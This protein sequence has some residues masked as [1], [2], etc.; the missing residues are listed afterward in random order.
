MEDHLPVPP[1][2]RA[3]SPQP[4]TGEEEREI[5]MPQP[6]PIAQEHMHTANKW[7][8]VSPDNFSDI[9]NCFKCN[10]NSGGHEGVT[11]MVPF[12]E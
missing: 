7:I 8:P 12:T 6:E 2:T 11:M 10:F 5:P 3:P 9:Y 4:G 1:N